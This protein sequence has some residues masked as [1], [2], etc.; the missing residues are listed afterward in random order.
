[1]REKLYDVA[2]PL[3]FETEVWCTLKRADMGIPETSY[4]GRRQS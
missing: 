2:K 3:F 4:L 1:M